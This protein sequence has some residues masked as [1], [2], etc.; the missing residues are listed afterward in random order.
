V[1]LLIDVLVDSPV[2]FVAPTGEPGSLSVDDRDSRRDYFST[3]EAAPVVESVAKCVQYAFWQ[4]A[5]EGRSSPVGKD[6]LKTSP[7]WE[8]AD[9]KH[10]EI[11]LRGARRTLCRLYESD[12]RFSQEISAPENLRL[13]EAVADQLYRDMCRGGN[14]DESCLLSDDVG[15]ELCRRFLDVVWPVPPVEDTIQTEGKEL[16][17]VESLQEQ[18]RTQGGGTTCSER[19]IP[20]RDMCEHCRA[21]D[22]VKHIRTLLERGRMLANHLSAIASNDSWLHKESQAWLRETRNIPN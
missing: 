9:A 21:A 15:L 18:C 19:G 3:P 22:E 20:P 14:E 17:I 4:L 5:R 2:V 7:I 11:A 1:T 12:K 10:R 6:L 8:H 13:L 16:D